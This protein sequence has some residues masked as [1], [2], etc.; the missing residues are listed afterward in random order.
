L[1][2]LAV[3]KHFQGEEQKLWAKKWIEKGLIALEKVLEGSSGKYCVGDEVT[4]A[5]CCLGNRM[6]PFLF[7]KFFFLLI[8]NSIKLDL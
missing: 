7:F 1:Q 6:K 4:L 3:L 5:D 2:N 8:P